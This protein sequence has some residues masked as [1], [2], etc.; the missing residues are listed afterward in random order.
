MIDIHL[1]I[2]AIANF[3][4]GSLSLEPSTDAIVDTLWLPP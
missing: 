4:H 1:L 3:G 2:A